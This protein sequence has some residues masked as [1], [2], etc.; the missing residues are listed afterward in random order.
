M[1]MWKLTRFMIAFELRT[2]SDYETLYHCLDHWA[3]VPI[4]DGLW[5]AEIPGTA[6]S[7]RDVLRSVLDCEDGIAVLPIGDENNWA[8]IGIS[9]RGLQW[10]DERRKS[11]G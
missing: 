4:L 7:V 3:A 1:R 2:A 5:L 10:L 11:F 8:A 9:V 6:A